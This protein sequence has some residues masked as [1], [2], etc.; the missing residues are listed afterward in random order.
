MTHK[1]IMNHSFNILQW[2]VQGINKKRQ[3]LEKRFEKFDLIL[4]SETWLR[5]DQK[6]LIKNFDTVR[7]CRLN[8]RGG[9]VAIFIRNG[10]TYHTINIPYKV[11]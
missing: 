8:R 7:S 9:G 2:N 6:F 5:D 10:I 3:E 4:I 1:P 11:Q